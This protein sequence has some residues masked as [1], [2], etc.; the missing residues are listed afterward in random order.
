MFAVADHDN[1]GHI[2]FPEFM[3]MYDKRDSTLEK[4]IPRNIVY[5]SNVLH[6]LLWNSNNKPFS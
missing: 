6:T 1:D 5:S 2:G 4:Q 3:V